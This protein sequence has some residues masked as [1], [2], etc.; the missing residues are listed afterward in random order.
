MKPRKMCLFENKLNLMSRRR[1]EVRRHSRDVARP[2]RG[3]GGSTP[4]VA[5]TSWELPLRTPNLVFQFIIVFKKSQQ[6]TKT[7]VG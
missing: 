2:G 3:L 7:G 4:D 5:A 1:S 6:K